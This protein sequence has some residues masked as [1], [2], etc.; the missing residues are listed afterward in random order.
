MW[1]SIISPADGDSEHGLHPV[2]R[3]LRMAVECKQAR[4]LTTN[5]VWQTGLQWGQRVTVPAATERKDLT[6]KYKDIKTNIRFVTQSDYRRDVGDETAK[7][8]TLEYHG[9]EVTSNCIECCVRHSYHRQ[10]RDMHAS[11][12]NLSCRLLSI[13]TVCRD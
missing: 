3:A 1:V 12:C 8:E 5:E 13:N 4:H 11:K 6:E 9:E 10:Y 2:N 7:M